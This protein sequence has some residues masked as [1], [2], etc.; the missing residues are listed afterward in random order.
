VEN[1]AVLLEHVDLLNAGDGLDTELLEGGLELAVVTL[2][3]GHRLLDDLTTGSALAAC[4][5][6][7][8]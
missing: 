4:V 8:R 1:V 7:S 6:T 2:R 3:G 5:W